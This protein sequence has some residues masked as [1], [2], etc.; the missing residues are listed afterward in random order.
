MDN[1]QHI[2]ENGIST[3]SNPHILKSSHPQI[4]KS[5]NQNIFSFNGV[6]VTGP[7][8]PEGTV[9]QSAYVPGL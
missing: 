3:S 6:N 4:P 1:L 8:K 9:P 7:S 5:S 2:E